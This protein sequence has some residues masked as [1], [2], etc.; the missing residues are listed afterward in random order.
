MSWRI[1]PLVALCL[2]AGCSVTRRV[3]EG[4]Y[5]LQKVTV[6]PDDETPKKERITAAELERYVRQSPNKRFLGTN[7]YVW[8]YNLANPGKQNWWNNL[9]RKIGREPVLYDQALTERSAE[10]L[11]I[12]M[13]SRGYYSSEATYEVDTLRRPKRAYVT[14][15]TR[16]GLPYRIVSVKYDFRDRFLGQIL[17]PDT[18]Q[19]LVRRGE[20]LDISVLD[21]ERKRVTEYLK[22]RGYYDFSV[23]NIEYLV[24]TLM[25][26]R[27]AAVTMVVKQTVAGY[28]ER[29]EAVMDNNTV[30][31]IGEINVFP[32]FD[33]TVAVG[34][35][36]YVSRLD[37][38]SYRGLNIIAAGRPN[39]RARVLRAMIPIYPNS[40]YDID[41]VS[42]TYQDIMSMGYF[43]STKINFAVQPQGDAADDYVT[44]IGDGAQSDSAQLL[45]AREG[46]LTCNILCTPALKQSFKVELEASTTS[47]F[48]GVNATVGY[49]HRNIFRGA[50][51]FDAA[52]TVGY[53]YYIR[54]NTSHTRHA[55]E[56]GITAGLSFPRLLL[57]VRTV[58]FRSVNQPLTRLQLSMSFQDRPYYRRTLAGAMWTYS[59]SNNRYSSFSVSPANINVIDLKSIDQNFLDA[60]G[61]PYL[62]ESFRSQLVAGISGTYTYN[63]QRRN[64]GGDATL[65]RFNW[66][67]AGNLIQGLESLFSKHAAGEDY[68]TIFGLRYNQYFRVDLSVSHKIMLG[69][70][71]AVAGRLF[72]GF[73]M[74]YGNGQTLPYDRFFYAG[75]SN[76]MRGWTPRTLGPGGQLAPEYRPDYD[77]NRYNYPQQVGD[78]KLE[79]NIELRFPIW[80]IFYGA[81]FLDLGNVWMRRD[82]DPAAEFRFDRFYKQ[83][84]FNTGLGIRL[85]IKFAVL[86]LDWG[87]RLHDPNCPAGERW[88]HDFRWKNTALNFG[89][90]YPF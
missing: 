6:E 60:I 11:K 44:Y 3:P 10:N 12:Y 35:P 33:P 89:V 53:E 51:A 28:D 2:L 32:N 30:Y 65:V 39:V 71:T 49:Q 5:F 52:V 48:Y 66:E 83:L 45:R 68:Y 9:K 63:N 20:V 85:D 37:T 74:A 19:S 78:I 88:I 67:T 84:G 8:I 25:G 79:A 29:G 75:G 21:A 58:R 41:R 46:Y 15:R 77:R 22:Q 18:A 24:D 1:L 55:R 76:S 42:R 34:D 13:D 4:R 7:L 40:V 31:R 27:R 86:R 38:T 59:W 14:Y 36:D 62:R 70:K 16:Q 81:T 87:I 80:G 61:N 69:E 72:G 26:G 56:L 50:E 43:K 47:S 73:G 82:S 23:G 90:G 57:P 54:N 17:E 64:L